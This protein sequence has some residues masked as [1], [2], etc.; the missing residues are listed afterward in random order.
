MR[1]LLNCL[2]SA[3]FAVLS[4]AATPT[5]TAAH[6]IRLENGPI[7]VE[8]AFRLK[9]TLGEV[10]FASEVDAAVKQL[11]TR[12]EATGRC[13]TSAETAAAAQ[14]ELVRRTPD[15]QAFSKSRA[16]AEA[17]LARRRELRA[18]YLGG[19][20]APPPYGLVSR[21]AARAKA[22]P[23]PRLAQLYG[24]MAE[25]QFS[26][27][28]SMTLR[29]FAGPG[30]H[31][32]WEK[33]LDEAALAYVD[34]T[35][36]GEWCPMDHANAAW[37]KADLRAHGWYR[38]SVYGPD[39]DRAAW[40]IVQHARHDLAFQEEAL[41]MLEPLW[42]SGET[43]GEN[44]ALLY[45]QTAH[46]QGRPGRFGV[47]GRCTAPGVWTPDPVEDGSA[48]NAWRAK[49][50]MPPLAQYVATRSRGCTGLGRIE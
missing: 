38:I 16:A 2:I 14:M 27:I 34:A 45:D 36:G 18:L 26:R 43:R 11:W 6:P 15:P 46:Y 33:G 22:E 7:P 35:I 5:A 10:T 25:D 47:T 12:N 8:Q 21:M 17:A 39:A 9:A 20:K 44:Y 30:V 49:A 32:E 19:A 4:L 29:P 24:R 37:L 48:T 42:Q 50:G 28:D 13:A 31:T 3:A 41:A 1:T 23:N 40:A